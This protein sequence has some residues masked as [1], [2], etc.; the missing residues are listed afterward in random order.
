MTANKRQPS[1]A[2]IGA[3]SRVFGF[4]MC[5]DICQ[6]AALKGADIRLIDTDKERLDTTCR[7]FKLVSDRTG[8]GLKISSSQNRVDLLPDVDFAI[9]SVA[10]E[11]IERWDM[12]LAIS[13]KHGI[14]EVQGEGGG[15]GGLSLTLRNIPLVVGIA[16]DIK[17][18]A[19]KAVILNFTNPMTRVCH[20]LN[21]YAGLPT[22]GLA[23]GLLGAQRKLSN[24][25]GRPITVQSCGINHCT[26]L[27]DA[28]WADTEENIWE[29]TISAFMQKELGGYKYAQEL[30]AIFGRIPVPDDVHITDFLPH[31]RDN[32][33]GLLPR[34]GLSPKNMAKYHKKEE[35]WKNRLTRYFL[36]ETNPVDDMHGLSGEGAIPIICTMAGL[37]PPYKE[38]AV[39]IPNEGYIT[40][41][42]DGSLVEIPAVIEPHKIKGQSMGALPG[43]IASIL[44]RQLDIAE[45][46]V[47]AAMEGS[48]Q[49]ALQALALDPIIPDLQIARNYLDDILDAHRPLLPQFNSGKITASKV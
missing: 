3:G 11:R 16:R 36:G 27:F 41:L 48:Y 46:A 43:G 7:L 42:P 15:P 13:K 30:A 37:T 14:I 23:H 45:L 2:L 49:K 31:W 33:N 39:N 22:I 4:N 1:I 32:E 10:E 38:I 21:R 28:V 40:N 26:W 5:S 34:Y 12:D 18:L 9:I 44:R 29:K 8:W 19:P 35:E 20:A 25:L 6:T 24:L 47:E 17:R